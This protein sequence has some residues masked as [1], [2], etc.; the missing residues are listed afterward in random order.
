MLVQSEEVGLGNT[1]PALNLIT[2][3]VNAQVSSASSSCRGSTVVVVV[4]ADV[5]VNDKEV[6][7][8][9]LEKL[10]VVRVLVSV[11]VMSSV[12]A[13]SNPT[14]SRDSAASLLRFATVIS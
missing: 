6:F 13:T 4:V 7:D 11:F 1:T 8:V 2:N 3:V 5:A 10:D 12:L 14:I 9:V